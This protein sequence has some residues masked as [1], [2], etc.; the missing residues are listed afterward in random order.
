MDQIQNEFNPKE[1]E[2]IPYYYFKN[3]AKKFEIDS[4]R[5]DR[6]YINDFKVLLLDKPTSIKKWDELI[7]EFVKMVH[8]F[9][10]N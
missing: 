4:F 10:V 8:V 9:N 3:E 2:S 5:K 6:L 7:K 1:L